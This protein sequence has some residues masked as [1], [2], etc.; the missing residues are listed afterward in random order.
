MLCALTTTSRDNVLLTTRDKA[1]RYRAA[2]ARWQEEHKAALAKRDDWLA[3]AQQPHRESLRQKKIDSLPVSDQQKKL[4]KDEPDS[5]AAK[6][7]AR[8][9]QKAL[10]LT[11]VDFRE[12]FTAE[13]RRTWDALNAEL[14]GVQR[15]KPPSPP[16]SLAIVDVKSEP[17]PT[18]LLE[19]GDF[20]ARK[21]PL[22]LGFLS[23]LTR[24]R[25][26]GEYWAAA[27]R[28]V[29]SPRSTLQRRAF[30]G[31]KPS[32]PEL[33]E[34]LAND[35]VAG[36][37]RLKRL[38]RLI[39]TSNVYLQDTTFDESRARSDPDNRLWWRRRPLRL[40]AEIV[41]DAI[42][43]I[44][45]TLN[46]RQFGPAFKPPIPAEAIVAR[47]TKSPYPL[48]A[49]DTPATRRRTVYMFHKRVTPHP[50][51]QVFDEPDAAVSCGRRNTTT[52]APQAL[53]LL[54]DAFV[55]ERAIDLAQRLLS[56]DTTKPEKW[57]VDA[58]WLALSRPPAGDEL[59][60]SITFL[61]SQLQRR[62][63]REPSHSQDAIRLQS[64]AD[65]CQA[66]IS[67]NEFIYVD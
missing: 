48:D 28:E 25:E 64:L 35:L 31:E 26:P 56:H 20:Y 36:D 65:F 3:K 50:L 52:V 54:N 47:N 13:E 38:H 4:L 45:G 18:W 67:L 37:W 19:R 17:Q 40:E 34:W 43:A 57:I 61:Q 33:L 11:D 29:E 2:D 5:D 16:T 41:R 12:V 24:D 62:A 7:L 63:A 27:R 14:A 6:R 22:E 49:R 58:Y 59:A 15:R 1:D 44:S 51:M 8:Q 9:H 39:L 66:L 30:R 10:Q 55:R 60:A 32:H 23:V 21:E 42:L 46:E 53:A